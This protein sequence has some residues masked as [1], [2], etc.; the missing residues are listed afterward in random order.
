MAPDAGIDSL[1]PGGDG[2]LVRQAMRELWAVSPGP[3]TAARILAAD[4]KLPFPATPRLRIA[5]ERSATL[6]PAVPL[7]R[8]MGLLAGIQIDLR[9]GQFNAYP[10]AILD[11]S[12][13]LYQFDPDVLILAVEL[14]DVAPELETGRARMGRTDAVA[15]DAVVDRVKQ[16]LESLVRSFRSLSAASIVVH[17]LRRPAFAPL[18]LAMVDDEELVDEINQH[19]RSVAAA[20]PGVYVLDL[21]RVAARVGERA[22]T[23]ERK[24]VTSR[25]AASGTGLTALVEEWMRF[26]HPLSGVVSK[27][28]VADLDGVLWG[29]TLGEEG[30]EGIVLDDGPVG[31]AYRRVQEAM[32]ALTKRGILLALASKNDRNEAL[33]VLGTHPSMILAPDDFAGIEI[34]WGDKAASVQRIAAELEVGIDAIAFLDDNVVERSRI[35][36]ALP[37][38]YVLQLPPDPMQ[39]ASVIWREPRFER[40][41]LTEED[42]GRGHIYAAQRSRRELMS[43]LPSLEAFYASLQQ[44][45][46]VQPLSDETLSRASQ[47]TQRTNQ[48]NVTTRRYSPQQLWALADS[49]E[50]EILLARV[51]DRFGDNGLV[52]LAIIRDRDGVAEIDTFLLSCRVVGR[53]VETAL[54]ADIAARARKRGITRLIGRFV[55][56]PRNAPAADFFP[57]HGFKPVS[58]EASSPEWNLDLADGPPVVPPWIKLSDP[59]LDDRAA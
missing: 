2:A 39:F 5:I 18:G 16:E 38:A 21:D 14:G 32:L 13:D 26:I 53:T 17:S 27:V 43:E 41:V 24:W 42:K 29:G 40:L 31:A 47:L 4:R 33:S 59:D 6:E 49:G 7:L 30:P 52:A 35:A 58:G 8:A 23:D 10:A 54:L 36:S 57:R 25:L 19:L 11:P 51:T 44:T 45:V 46:I 56:S 15:I 3:A 9:L 37:N 22:W 12:S 48:F 28:L 20:L 50:C 1:I 55:P 34:G